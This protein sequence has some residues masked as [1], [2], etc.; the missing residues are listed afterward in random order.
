MK[1]DKTYLLEKL[2]V[3]T[4]LVKR[5]RF[6][7]AFLVFSVMYGYVLTQV[8]AIDALQPSDKQ[9][10][11]KATDAPR[12]KV[13][14]ELAEKIISLEDQNVQIQTIFSEARKNPFAE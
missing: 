12:T 13:D 3:A 4:A 10:A 6:I 11:E 7:I 2:A 1:L 9:I 5:F 14:E 8:N